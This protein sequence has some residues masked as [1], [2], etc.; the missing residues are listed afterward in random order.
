MRLVVDANVAVK[1]YVDQIDRPKALEVQAYAKGL[2]AP[3][4]LLAECVSAFW[5]HVRHTDITAEHASLAI[6]ALPGCFDEIVDTANLGGAALALALDL[7]HS[8]WDCFYLVLAEQRDGLLVTADQK[9]FDKLAMKRR[10]R[11]VTL[12]WNWTNP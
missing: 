2:L 10:T 6:D 9:F 7:A 4:I 5:M 11:N 8:P 12:L 3:D 1:W